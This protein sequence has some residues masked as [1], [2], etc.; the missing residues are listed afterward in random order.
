M[1]SDLFPLHIAVM[2]ENTAMLECL[3]RNGANPNLKVMNVE[4][5]PDGGKH[6]VQC[7]KNIVDLVIDAADKKMRETSSQTPDTKILDILI[8]YKTNIDQ[9]IRYSLIMDNIQIFSYLLDQ[10]PDVNSKF[11][12]SLNLE[13]ITGPVRS[14]TRS[15]LAFPCTLFEFGCICFK[16]FEY[17]D[18]LL[19]R[20]AVISPLALEVAI[21]QNNRRL[22]KYL[23]DNGAGCHLNNRTGR[24]RLVRIHVTKGNQ[25]YDLCKEIGTSD[26]NGTILVEVRGVFG[27]ILK[28]MGITDDISCWGS[29]EEYSPEGL[30]RPSTRPMNAK[31]QKFRRKCY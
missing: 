8:R 17:L 5:D 3:L 1:M 25:Y 21:A 28:E 29:D 13:G 14:I 6:L 22:L 9:G 12:S 20:G 19:S 2:K 16:N 24:H 4:F 30:S 23:M 27:D 26:A 18:L 31:A 10:W 15:S 11:D 7:S